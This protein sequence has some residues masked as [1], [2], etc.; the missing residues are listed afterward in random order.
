MATVSRDQPNDL[1]VFKMSKP[2]PKRSTNAATASTSFDPGTLDFQPFLS[3]DVPTLV[4]TEYVVGNSGDEGK[5]AGQGVANSGEEAGG[6]EFFG[7]HSSGNRFVFVVDG[8]TS[9]ARR[10]KWVDCMS[11]LLRAVSQLNEE[12]Y[13]YVYVFSYNTNRM[14][15]RYNLATDLVRATPEN[16]QQLR[17]WLQGYRLQGGTIPLIALR[18]SLQ[19]LKPDSVYLLSDGQF[20]DRGHTAKFL[21]EYARRRPPTEG[22]TAPAP[23][24]IVVHTIA[25]HSRRGEALLKSIAND[26]HGTFRYVSSN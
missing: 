10:N 26:Y 17:A 8:S 7:I 18:E 24:E 14:F 11:E 21:R 23:E 5:E 16:F 13:F 9:M 6:I 22:T 1:V 20:T 12:Q 4:S 15:G 2:A 19:L 3:V 25:F